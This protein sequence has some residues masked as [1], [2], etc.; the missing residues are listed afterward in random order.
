M[1]TLKARFESFMSA[2]GGVENI[3]TLMKRCNLP[4]RQRADYLAFDRRVIIEQKSLDVD[5]DQKV[6]SFIDDLIRE[7]GPLAIGQASLTSVARILEGLPDG[8]NR[9]RRLYEKLTKGIDDILAKADKQTADTRLTFALPLSLGVG[10]VVILN[11]SAQ[12]LE[13]DYVVSRVWDTLHK[14][15]A[16]GKLRY[17]NNEL[18]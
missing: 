15:S 13:P 17:Q 18:L 12:I 16:T 2:L 1:T 14:R 8:Y 7:R 11:E 5:P 3:D 4:G 6:Q 9:K 10:M